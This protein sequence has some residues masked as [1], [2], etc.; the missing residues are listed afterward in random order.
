MVLSL[1]ENMILAFTSILL[2]MLPAAIIEVEGLKK[3]SS[4]IKSLAREGAPLSFAYREHLLRVH[5]IPLSFTYGYFYEVLEER[6][7]DL[8]KFKAITFRR[9]V[10]RG[11]PD[12]FLNRAQGVE[13]R[14]F[15]LAKAELR[16]RRLWHFERIKPVLTFGNLTM[17]KRRGKK[18]E[19][20]PDVP[21]WTPEFIDKLFKYGW[22][23]LDN[24]MYSAVFRKDSNE[25]VGSQRFIFAPATIVNKDMYARGRFVRRYYG[26]KEMTFRP[27]GVIDSEEVLPRPPLRLPEANYL[28]FDILGDGIEGAGA[29][30]LTREVLNIEVG[31]YA[32]DNSLSRSDYFTVWKGLWMN[33]YNLAFEHP[34]LYASEYGTVF[35]GYANP[36]SLALY[37]RMGAEPLTRF[38]KDGEIVE[39]TN[40]KDVPPIWVGEDGPW[41]PI[42]LYPSTIRALD[43]HFG[44]QVEEKD[45]SLNPSLPKFSQIKKLYDVESHDRPPGRND[46]ED[47]FADLLRDDSHVAKSAINEIATL[48]AF[49]VVHKLGMELSTTETQR[50]RGQNEL[51]YATS[52]AFKLQSLI[53]Q[54]L[55]SN[56][57]LKRL[58]V[59][60]ILE[61]M[62]KM[63]GRDTVIPIEWQINSVILPVLY[64]SGAEE[65]EAFK[66]ALDCLASYY[67][68]KEILKL[69]IPYSEQAYIQ[70]SSAE[71][72][73]SSTWLTATRIEKTKKAFHKLF[74]I[75][76]RD[77]R[78]TKAGAI[79]EITDLIVGLPWQIHL[80]TKDLLIKDFLLLGAIYGQYVEAP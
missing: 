34:S 16:D 7:H 78:E 68:P 14:A 10:R 3:C 39:Y 17:A 63:G 73:L 58:R 32:I 77:Q 27:P 35:H 72:R 20:L 45:G 42:V 43:E 30:P 11:L 53:L 13:G 71:A 49:P 4:V 26:L 22:E 23:Y 56:E 9:S 2:S 52:V 18:N 31:T 6:E 47:L 48:L 29:H 60:Q 1:P 57:P 5:H 76:T 24:S 28:G 19:R 79:N 25:V 41:T 64:H 80:I 70:M 61:S 12:E 38:Q 67:S 50:R 46:L 44:R 74:Q 51:A 8:G 75:G 54:L 21:V 69:L 36:T 15:D 59:I 65:E 33:W 40:P 66:I 62:L 55:S 37:S